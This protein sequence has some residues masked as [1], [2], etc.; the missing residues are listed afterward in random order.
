[1]RTVISA[2]VSL[3]IFVAVGETASRVF[4]LVDRL[5]GFPRRLFVT[6]DDPHLPYVMRPGMDT[7]VRAVR[8][9]V[10]ALGMRGPEASPQPTPGVHRILA[11]GDS[12]TFGEY[13]PVDE[14]FPALLERMLTDG[15]PVV[16]ALPQ[17]G[18]D[19]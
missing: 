2:L 9:Q 13:L 10:N 3:A 19:G 6:T 17:A 7:S 18:V 14:A 1:M 11:L 12:A 15:E 16:E 8:V 5:N 4:D